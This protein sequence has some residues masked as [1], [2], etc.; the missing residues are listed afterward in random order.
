MRM[1]SR[2]GSVR[3]DQD[4]QSVSAPSQSSGSSRRV[5]L[6]LS[7]NLCSVNRQSSAQT[8]KIRLSFPDKKADSRTESISRQK[9]TS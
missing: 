6:A 8:I 7:E 5:F 9:E 2:S 3:I 1:K 4:G